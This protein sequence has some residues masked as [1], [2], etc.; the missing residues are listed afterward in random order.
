MG[1]RV[2][3]GLLML[4]CFILPATV[5]HGFAEIKKSISFPYTLSGTDL[6]LTRLVLYRGEENG[7]L[8]LLAR[9][10]GKKYLSYISVKIKTDMGTFCFETITSRREKQQFCGMQLLWKPCR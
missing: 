9:N 3:H 10:V 6:S 8:G 7:R 5:L 4:L 2:F 1:K